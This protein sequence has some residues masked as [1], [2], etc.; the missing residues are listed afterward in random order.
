MPK[1]LPS[2]SITPNLNS[3]FKS[4][5]AASAPCPP[6]KS[7]AMKFCAVTLSTLNIM[8]AFE[9]ELDVYLNPKSLP[10][11]ESNLT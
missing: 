7:L 9:L 2:Q 8:G 5:V 11:G 6:G 4:P 10:F 1:D 3:L